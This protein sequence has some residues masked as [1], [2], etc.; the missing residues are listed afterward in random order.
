MQ[1]LLHAKQHV[2]LHVLGKLI[3]WMQYG[4]ARHIC[5]MLQKMLFMSCFAHMALRYYQ[6]FGAS[7]LLS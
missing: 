4:H 2:L 3:P 6:H 5:V 1:E 7:R